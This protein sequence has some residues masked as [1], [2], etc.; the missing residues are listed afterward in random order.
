MKRVEQHV[1][2]RSHAK[3]QEI[4][5][6]AFAAKN[7]WNLA[8]YHV[9]QSFMFQGKYLNYAALYPLL[10]GTDAYK[11]LP[12]KAANQV[13]IQ[14]DKAW[15]SFFEANDAYKAD[16]SKFTGRPCLPKYKHKTE[17]RSLLV[18]ELGA[19]WKSSLRHQEIAVSDLGFLVFTKQNTEHIEQVRIAPKADHYVVEVVY[20]AQAQPGHVARIPSGSRTWS[21]ARKIIKSLSRSPM[22]SSSRS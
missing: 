11:A 7:L 5:K 16:P 3:F 9:R 8:N 21:W 2:K 15:T 20:Q 13:L 19:I 12:A 4:D 17:G 14:L 10:K 1:M 18:F 22:P 6:M